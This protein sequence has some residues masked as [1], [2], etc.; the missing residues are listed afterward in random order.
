MLKPVLSILFVLCFVLSVFGQYTL[1]ISSG[2]SAKGGTF[3]YQINDKLNAYLGLNYIKA[4]ANLSESFSER[5]NGVLVFMD[6]DNIEF[7]AKILIPTL[8][9]KYFI[10]EKN[11]VK[12]YSNANVS[13]PMLSA[14]LIED[15]DIEE[16]LEGLSNESS[17]FGYE[18]SLGSEYFFDSNFSIG[19]EVGFQKLSLSSSGEDSYSFQA[20]GPNNP[21]IS[22]EELYTAEFNLS[23]IYSRF[24]MNFYF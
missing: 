20:G 1:S 3:G 11:K 4:Y 18:L 5:E 24:T 15:G 14:Q 17:S 2:L 8:G 12:L 6:D 19:G 13:F 7:E 9:V 23:V 10:L 22:G 16:E 21:V